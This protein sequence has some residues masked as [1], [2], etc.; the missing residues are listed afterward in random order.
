[1]FSVPSTYR[2]ITWFTG[3]TP[4]TLLDVKEVEALNFLKNISKPT[5]I[6]LTY[7]FGDLQIKDFPNPPVPMTYYNA[8]YV[9]FFTERHVY[10]ED[11]NSANLLSY[12][13]NTRLGYEKM[14]FSSESKIETRNFLT[15]NRIRYIYVVDSQRF[16]VIP[17]DIGVI[18][19]F[20]NKKA[21][22]YKVNDR[23]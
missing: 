11:L 15:D 9:S 7:P 12:D 16:N 17:E 5:D 14:F 1:M 6:L 2:T 18:E 20:N 22:I 3:S 21:R 8:P 4:T 23:I 19:I 10:L 13:V